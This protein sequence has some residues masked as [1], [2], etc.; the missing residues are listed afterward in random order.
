[1]WH[2]KREE[3]RVNVNVH[4]DTMAPFLCS[5]MRIYEWLSG[6]WDFC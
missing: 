1:M 5:G 6:N 4:M 3:E 2:K